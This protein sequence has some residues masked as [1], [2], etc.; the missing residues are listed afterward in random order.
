MWAD[1]TSIVDVLG[2]LVFLGVAFLCMFGTKPIIRNTNH[3]NE[4]N[5]DDG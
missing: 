1:H 4:K 5:H 3:W 2:A